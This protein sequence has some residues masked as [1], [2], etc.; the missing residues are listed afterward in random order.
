MIGVAIREIPLSAGCK[1]LVRRPCYVGDNRGGTNGVLSSHPIDRQNLF[2]TGLVIKNLQELPLERIGDA[3][4]GWRDVQSLR[5]YTATRS[6][7]Q[8]DIKDRS[9][10]I[11]R[12][13]GSA[14]FTESQ[15]VDTLTHAH[16]EVKPQLERLFSLALMSKSRARA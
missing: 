8:S 4:F 9:T 2:L 5:T 1:L 12:G 16:S 10:S 13:S 6:G 3:P 14:R 7:M 15:E 11:P